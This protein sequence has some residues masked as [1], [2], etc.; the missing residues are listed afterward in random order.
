MDEKYMG[1]LPENYLRVWR[2]MTAYLDLAP[3]RSATGVPDEAPG[4][5]LIALAQ[6]MSE[7]P[8]WTRAVNLEG[9]FRRDKGK[10][11]LC[12]RTASDCSADLRTKAVESAHWAWT[13]SGPLK[14]QC[15]RYA[16]LPPSSFANYADRSE[17]QENLQKDVVMP[18]YRAYLNDWTDWKNKRES[19]HAAIPHSFW[20]VSLTCSCEETF[21]KQ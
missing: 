19:V 7:H 20:C 21:P 18:R 17:A 15:G 10:C 3:V 4:D 5:D 6:S 12:E 16:F 9:Q 1:Y 2:Y 13:A 8:A 11:P 14:N